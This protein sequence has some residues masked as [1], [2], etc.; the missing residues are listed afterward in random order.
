MIGKEFGFV[1]RSHRK[2]RREHDLQK[3]SV[4]LDQIR[5]SQ[6]NPTTDERNNKIEKLAPDSE[7]IQNAPPNQAQIKSPQRQNI[8]FPNLKTQT[9]PI[10]QLLEN[11]SPKLYQEKTTQIIIDDLRVNEISSKIQNSIDQFFVSG[12][13]STILMGDVSKSMNQSRILQLLKRREFQNP[14]P[15][16]KNLP[17]LTQSRRIVA[18]RVSQYPSEVTPKSNEEVQSPIC[19]Q[20]IVAET[21]SSVNDRCDTPNMVNMSRREEYGMVENGSMENTPHHLT[22]SRFQNASAYSRNL[23]ER[24]SAYNS[25]RFDTMKNNARI[26]VFVSMNAKHLPQMVTQETQISPS[27][28]ISHR[29]QKSVEKPRVSRS[30][31]LKK[32]VLPFKE[33][34]LKRYQESDMKVQKPSFVKIKARQNLYKLLQR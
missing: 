19:E 33:E 24:G 25:R 29:K 28:F 10:K 14:I 27:G 30:L 3:E 15:N 20:P 8:L 2:L 6:D 1:G 31:E 26:Q 22:N 7:N 23:A 11:L 34:M 16:Q 18:H 32:F 13:N 21:A 9:I 5:V 4:L 12:R 17:F